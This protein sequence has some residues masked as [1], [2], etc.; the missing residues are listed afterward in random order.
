[1]GKR[2]HELPNKKFDGDTIDN[3]F[4][5]KDPYAPVHY[6]KMNEVFD[7]IKEK[8]IESGLKVEMQGDEIMFIKRN[9][10]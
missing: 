6:I 2:I 9:Q 1:M 7:W 8:A 10:S 5:V 3:C 4:Y